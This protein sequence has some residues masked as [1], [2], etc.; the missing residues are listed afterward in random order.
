MA[1]L[2]GLRSGV[3]SHLPRSVDQ[4]TI[5]R[6]YYYTGWGRRKE[7][8]TTWYLKFLPKKQK[9]NNKINNCQPIQK[10]KKDKNQSHH[11]T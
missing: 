4:F 10:K 6:F 5:L 8:A 3:F 11:P 9:T 1:L 7:L 2:N